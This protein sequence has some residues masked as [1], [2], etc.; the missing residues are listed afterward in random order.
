MWG[1]RGKAVVV[2]LVALFALTSCTEGEVRKRDNDRAGS[3]ALLVVDDSGKERWVKVPRAV[4]D[5]CQVEEEYPACAGNQIGHGGVQDAPEEGYQGRHREDKDE[6]NGRPGP[7]D[8]GDCAEPDRVDLVATWIPQQHMKVVY[9]ITDQK[10]ASEQRT[11]DKFGGQ[12][13]VTRWVC[14]GTAT[15]KLSLPRGQT[16]PDYM[17][18]LIRVNG[19]LVAGDEVRHNRKNHCEAKAVVE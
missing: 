5:K 12:F 15:I 10:G 16:T 6:D 8:I 14:R 18:C 1:R 19:K 9:R 11:V 17:H 4:F 13:N 2:G 7:D 3:P